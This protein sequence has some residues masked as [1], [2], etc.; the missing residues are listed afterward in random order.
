[1]IECRDLA[2][3]YTPAHSTGQRFWQLLWGRANRVNPYWALH[4]VSFTLGRGEVLGVVGCNG[5][6]KSTLL[7]L[8]CGTLSPTVGEVV[9][10]GRVAA[11][12]ELGAGFN[13]DFTGRENAVLN[14]ALLGLSAQEVQRK[15]PDI[16]AFADIGR[17]IDEPVKTYSSGMFVRLAFAVAV[18]VEPEILIVDEALSVGDG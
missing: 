10:R 3:A 11:L 7:Q 18:S 17:F 13:P 12:L 1:M 8:L 5:A 2:K 16:L 14:A 15:L 9:V 6:G 4:G